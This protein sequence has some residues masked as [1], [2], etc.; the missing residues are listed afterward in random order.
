MPYSPGQKRTLML[1]S[2][3]GAGIAPAAQGQLLDGCVNVI[4]LDKLFALYQAAG[5]MNF[6]NLVT[7][8]HPDILNSLVRDLTSQQIM[9]FA[10]FDAG[11]RGSLKSL[12]SPDWLKA[13]IRITSAPPPA[14]FVTTAALPAGIVNNNNGIL[15]QTAIQPALQDTVV[16]E[17]NPA[18]NATRNLIFNADGRCVGEI[19]FANHTGTAVSGHAHIYPVASMPLTGHHIMGTPHFV[20]GDYPAIWRTLPVG[21]NPQ[22]PLGT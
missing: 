14:T 21:V 15:D 17:L 9:V 22:T 1:A 4:G 13:I 5:G 19:N 20:M 16:T 11:T 8:L 6:R 3:G 10:A 7:S 18:G 12:V 2:L